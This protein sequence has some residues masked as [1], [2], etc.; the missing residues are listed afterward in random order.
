V[1]KVKLPKHVR[2]GGSPAGTP[3]RIPP[4]V[5]TEV[6][7]GVVGAQASAPVTLS[8]EG[9]GGGNG[10]ATVDR[11]A[12]ASV[13]A[14]T[15]VKL[16]GVDQTAD[17]K[18]GN[19][20]LVAEQ[21][22]TR[23]ASS[24]PFSVAAYPVEIGFAFH[25]VMSP[26]V[27]EGVKAWG[28]SYDLTAASDSKVAGDLDLTKIAENVIVHTPRG[29]FKD[30][31]NVHSGFRR[32]TRR[33]RD[34]HGT[35]IEDGN[36]AA[37]I[38]AIKRVGVDRSTQVSHQFY[39]FSCARSGLAEDKDAGPKVPTSGFKITHGTSKSGP[40]FFMDVRKVGFA[41]NRV[42]AGTVDDTEEK[43]AEVKD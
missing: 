6:T 40:T 4:R 14:D 37:M 22:T 5:D 35:G 36:A 31:E 13:A 26:T 38:A 17:G 30:A 25:A 33:Q 9:G 43:H 19:L 3:D 39:R 2:G 12:T 34:H 10:S 11:A 18:A 16:R 28:A 32:T 1:S 20:R 7:V 41:N 24:E 42:A 8:I 27:V 23:L 15:T 21:G 29:I